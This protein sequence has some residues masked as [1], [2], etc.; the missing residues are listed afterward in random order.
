MGLFEQINL[1]YKDAFK[2]RDKLK[3]TVLSLVISSLKKRQIDEK[4]EM[5]DDIVLSSIKNEA[6]AIKE[7]ISYLEKINTENS[8]NSIVEEKVKLDILMKYLPQ[9][10]SEDETRIIVK[11]VIDKLGIVDLQS[12]RWKLMWAIMWKYKWKIDWWIVNKIVFE[13]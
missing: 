8:I 10:M 4:I 9:L 13:L 5:T 6:K 2:S 11:E 1:D 3:K 12:E 7:T